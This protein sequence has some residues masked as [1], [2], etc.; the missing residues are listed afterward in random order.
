MSQKLNTIATTHEKELRAAYKAR[1]S[2]K[3]KLTLEESKVSA[4]EKDVD[5]FKAAVTQLEVEKVSLVD[6]HQ[7]EVKQLKQ[8]IEDA[9][10]DAA[11]ADE[12]CKTWNAASDM[13]EN[14][15][16]NL[17]KMVA[18]T[19]SPEMEKKYQEWLAIIKVPVK[20]PR[21]V[22]F[23]PPEAYDNDE[24]E[25]EGEDVATRVYDPPMTT[26]PPAS[27]EALVS[28]DP[29]GPS[30]PPVDVR[31]SAPADSTLPSAS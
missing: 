28:T 17:Q 25:D 14:V 3:T 12:V 18:P 24:S 20:E 9:E 27:D 21:E 23:I 1:D 2:A 16:S 6:E 19:L 22:E 7:R 11:N 13:Y 30:N 15:L 31:D 26:D 4:L 29:I 5:N 8:H 10:K